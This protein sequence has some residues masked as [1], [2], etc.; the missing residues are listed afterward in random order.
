MHNDVLCLQA[1]LVRSHTL[2]RPGHMRA[3]ISKFKFLNLKSHRITRRLKIMSSSR[4]FAHYF[5]LT[6]GTANYQINLKIE[7]TKISSNLLFLSQ[8]F[9]LICQGFNLRFQTTTILCKR[10]AFDKNKKII[11]QS[12]NLCKFFN[13][14]KSLIKT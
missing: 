8:M 12:L 11:I 10:C 7:E 4:T 1:E 13:Q 3:V 5:R 6:P 9:N 2:M 14:T